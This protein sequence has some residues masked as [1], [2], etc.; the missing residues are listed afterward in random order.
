[1]VCKPLIKVTGHKDQKEEYRWSST[2]SL[3]LALDRG[4]S[5]IPHLR[6]F[7]LGK[8]YG[9]PCTGQW[10]GSWAGLYGY[11]KSCPIGMQA[12]DCPAHT[13]SSLYFML[14]S[15]ITH[16]GSAWTSRLPLLSSCTWKAG[17]KLFQDRIIPIKPCVPQNTKTSGTDNSY[18]MALRSRHLHSGFLQITLAILFMLCELL[19][20]LV[21]SILIEATHFSSGWLNQG[22]GKCSL[23]KN[24]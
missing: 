2:L 6:H 18:L 1:M 13:E 19:W 20:K 15:S 5:L 21:N 22:N 8:R 11:R 3:S 4:M 7:T 12:T 17:G 14:S 16:L 24:Q 9:T 23:F 10:M